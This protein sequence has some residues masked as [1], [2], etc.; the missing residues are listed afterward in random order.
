MLGIVSV[1][2]GVAYK[3]FYHILLVWF[4]VILLRGD[5]WGFFT[6]R[7]KR[8]L[9][10]T[11]LQPRKVPL[12]FYFINKVNFRL[13][14]ILVLNYKCIFDWSFNYL[15]G[16]FRTLQLY[17][18]LFRKIVQGNFII[19]LTFLIHLLLTISCIL[20]LLRPLLLIINVAIDLLHQH[21]FLILQSLD[22][23]KLPWRKLLRC[24]R[25]LVRTL[26]LP[27]TL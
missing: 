23:L 27:K 5:C 15:V 1:D 13:G 24:N 25:A 16:L 26:F 20:E 18:H 4:L 11:L 21:V 7:L 6:L 17:I 2:L 14:Y 3:L 19:Q 10:A 12:R 9:L 22:F 8:H